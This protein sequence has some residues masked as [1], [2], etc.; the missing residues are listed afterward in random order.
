MLLIQCQ[1]GKS[2]H[3]LEINI[4]VKTAEFVICVQNLWICTVND[5]ILKNVINIHVYS[6][7]MRT[8]W[9]VNDEPFNTFGTLELL[10]P[11]SKNEFV[12]VLFQFPKTIILNNLLVPTWKTG[13][14]ITL[15]GTAI[16]ADYLYNFRSTECGSR[17]AEVDGKGVIGPG[18]WKL[19]KP[20]INI[21]KHTLKFSNCVLLR[22]ST[23]DNNYEQ[24]TALFVILVK[25]S[26]ESTWCHNNCHLLL[27][28]SQCDCH[29]LY[30]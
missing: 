18:H 12:L 8:Q 3:F 20:C 25:N 9:P 10:F 2:A 1:I 14:R 13:I 26:H 29:D 28:P 27:A 30:Y 16:S 6:K 15:R 5:K 22:V 11:I 4:F 17:P 23:N 21:C 19:R 7:Y 24:L